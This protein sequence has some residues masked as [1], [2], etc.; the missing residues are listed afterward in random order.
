[1]VRVHP[2]VLVLVHV[3]VN[4]KTTALVLRK[5]P[6]RSRSCTLWHFRSIVKELVKRRCSLV[7][8]ANPILETSFVTVKY[9]LYFSA[10]DITRREPK[11]L[12]SSP[13]RRI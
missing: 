13:G 11:K 4:W 3:K 2:G 5:L 6:V 9:R 8:R 7:H 12:N 10:F 1:M